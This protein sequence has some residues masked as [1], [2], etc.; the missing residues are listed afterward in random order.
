MTKKEIAKKANETFPSRDP[1]GR[2]IE[3]NH[4]RRLRAQGMLK[5]YLLNADETRLADQ[6]A[7]SLKQTLS[8]RSR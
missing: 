3:G 5:A 4:V 1:E 6:R 7:W 2:P 8:R